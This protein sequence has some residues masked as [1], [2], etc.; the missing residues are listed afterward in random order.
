VGPI[1][2]FVYRAC[3]SEAT[4]RKVGNVHRFAD[5]DNLTYLDFVL[6]AGAI[7]PILDSAREYALGEV[8]LQSIEATRSVVATNTNLG[9]VLLLAPLSQV[10]PEVSLREGVRAILNSTTI[11]DS[12]HTYAAIRKAIPGG[13]G[14]VDSQDIADAPTLALRDVMALSAEYDRIGRQYAT[15]FTEIFEIG[16]PAFMRAWEQCRRLE[17][18]I[19]GCQLVW[20]ASGGDSLIAR[21]R[22]VDV[23]RQAQTQAAQV[24]AGELSLEAFDT[25]LRADGH[26]RNPGTTADL[27]TASLFVAWREGLLPA[28]P[29]AW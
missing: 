6:S 10:P 20:L 16:V 29:L 19:I 23:S 5:F 3:I 9:I 18:A 24:L 8:I 13:L 1:G 2:K 22:G 17:S 15:D 14:A 4:A 26:A 11:A 25:W 7:A 27:V 21:K 12:V 28:G